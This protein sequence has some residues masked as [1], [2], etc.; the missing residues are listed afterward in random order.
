[1]RAAVEGLKAV[2]AIVDE[3]AKVGSESAEPDQADNGRQR[4]EV[5]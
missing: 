3:L 5:E 4:I 1:M 2:E